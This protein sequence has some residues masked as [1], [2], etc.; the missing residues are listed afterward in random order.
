MSVSG[1]SVSVQNASVMIQGADPTLLQQ[2]AQKFPKFIATI[3]ESNG[4]T[5]YTYTCLNPSNAKQLADQL[6]QAAIPL[7]R[8]EKTPPSPAQ[9]IPPLEEM[10]FSS[11]EATPRSPAQAG[12]PLRAEVIRT[13][14]Q[15]G[16][17]V[18]AVRIANST[19][20]ILA[21]MK[22]R[23]M[24]CAELGPI[25]SC[26][27][28]AG[29]QTVADRINQWLTEDS[30]QGDVDIIKTT[31]HGN[32]TV[33]LQRVQGPDNKPPTWRVT[34]KGRGNTQ[35]QDFRSQ[36]DATS[37]FHQLSSAL[38]PSLQTQ[39]RMPPPLKISNNEAENK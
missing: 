28:A 30:L 14:L 26:T 3:T 11:S 37:I 29:A 31:T 8:G 1:L 2:V 39:R 4:F 15:S 23:G 7:L 10:S 21:A 36:G 20:E 16:L 33:Q 35:S 13:T 34:L 24:P 38:P 6:T 25:I 18:P 17:Q 19:P 22:L 12:A 32:T 9:A 27:S 5:T